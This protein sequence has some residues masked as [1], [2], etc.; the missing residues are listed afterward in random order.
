MYNNLKRIVQTDDTVVITVEMNHDARVVRLGGEHDP[1]EIRKWLGDSVGHWEGDTLVV[2]TKNFRDDVGFFMGSRDMH[3]TERFERVDEE[4]LLYSF[5][6]DDPSTF[7]KPFTGEYP[8]PASRG[9]VTPRT[10]S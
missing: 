6:V 10:W 1:P 7:T 2:S 8:W 4:T 5:T 9:I 3:I